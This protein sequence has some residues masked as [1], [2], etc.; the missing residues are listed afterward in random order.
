[1]GMYE[2]NSAV[3]DLSNK[4]S[5]DRATQEYG[6]FLGQQRFARQRQE[7]DR[8]FGEGFGRMTGGLARRF[9]S[10]IGSGRIGATVADYTNGYGRQVGQ[11][12]QE[13]AQ[14]NGDF[15]MRSAQQDANY[16]AAMLRLKEQLDAGRALTDPFAIYR[17]VWGQ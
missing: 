14:Y 3:A 5:Q 13:Q 17:N 7:L 8:G 1:M 2:Y 6:R 15:Q 16:R 12:D 11:L 10:K 4:Y 9:G